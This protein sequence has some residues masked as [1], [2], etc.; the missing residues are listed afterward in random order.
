MVE[1]H[2]VQIDEKSKVILAYL[3][4]YGKEATTDEITS[5]T[6]IDDNDIVRYRYREKLFPTNLVKGRKISNETHDEVW[7]V[8][9]TDRAISA[10]QRGQLGDFET[11]NIKHDD[12]DER[13]NHHAHRLDDLEDRAELHDKRLTEQ[14]EYIAAVIEAVDGS[15][16]VDISKEE[17]M[18]I[19][20]G[21]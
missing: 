13:L 17:I 1:F 5:E 18:E 15:D 8:T 7:Q 19:S 14:N 6:V 11:V 3:Y 21:F 12:K 4:N 2:G 20:D 16:E 9:L 10:I